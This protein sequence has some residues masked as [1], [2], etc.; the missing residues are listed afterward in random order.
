MLKN[1]VVVY[2]RTNDLFC[3]CCSH[4]YTTSKI[5][6]K[7]KRMQYCVWFNQPEIWTSD[8]P[9]QRLTRYSSTNATAATFLRKELCCPG[10]MTRRWAP[11]TRYTLQRYTESIMKDLIFT[12]RMLRSDRFRVFKSSSHPKSEGFHDTIKYK[13]QS[14]T[15]HSSKLIEKKKKELL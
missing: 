10:A 12:T 4:Q 7:T 14:T 2:E 13:Y 1:F 11:Q 8:L 9:L 6:K 3:F 15:R 5:L